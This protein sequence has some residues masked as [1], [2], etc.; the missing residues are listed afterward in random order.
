MTKRIGRGFYAAVLV[1]AVLAAWAAGC[2]KTGARRDLN[3]PL[4]FTCDING[5]LVPCGCFTGQFGG[6]TRLKTVLETEAPAQALRLDVG[7]A[8]GG[9]EDYHAIE[10]RYILRAFADLGYDALNVGHREARLGPE[11]LRELRTNSP[12]PILSANLLDAATRRPLFAPWRIVQRSGYRIGIVGVLDPRGL[13]PDLDPGLA[14]EPMD[15]ALQRVLPELRPQTDLIV[16]L[17]F[18]DEASLDRLADQFYE[19]HVILGGRV[20]QPA[21]DLKRQNRS[22]VYFVT[23]ESRALGFLRLRLKHQAP[24]EVLNHAIRL[25]HDRVAEAES[26]RALARQYRDEVRRTRLAVDDPAH[27]DANAVP[28]VRRLATYTGSARCVECHKQTGA[29]WAK[30]GHARAFRT[31]IEAEADADPKCIGCHAI[32]FGT[33]SG[34]QRALAGSKLVDVGCESCHGPGSLHVR[35]REGDTSI[36]FRFRTLVAGDCQKCHHGEFSRP[37]KWDQFWPPVK[38]GK[39]TLPPNTS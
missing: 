32:G 8:V 9:S 17:A 25:L 27:E 10:Y 39:E 20:S 19:A 37:F 13:E 38:H 16:L 22:I 36:D 35:L 30:T 11:R 5:R 12:V 15:T 23:N 26:V 2:S 24:T 29:A 28:G 21:Q 14:I 1:L 4:F 33:A 31:L 7:D 18:T 6:M 34:Y 3:L